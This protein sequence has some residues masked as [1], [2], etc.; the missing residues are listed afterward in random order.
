MAVT[1]KNAKVNSQH[2]SNKQEENDEE[3]SFNSH[4]SDFIMME[5]HQPN[6]VRTDLWRNYKN[7]VNTPSE[8]GSAYAMVSQSFYRAGFQLSAACKLNMEINTGSSAAPRQQQR[9]Q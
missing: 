3:N 6:N 7:H 9:C 5:E 8:N 4:L 2:A 1:V